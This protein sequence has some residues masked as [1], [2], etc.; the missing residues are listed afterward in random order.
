VSE[1]AIDPQV[2]AL[3]A[4]HIDSVV[5]AEILTLLHLLPDRDVTAA[6][7]GRELRIDSAWAEAQLDHL[8]QRGL[9]TCNRD[10]GGP[11]YKVGAKTPALE[12]A[13]RGLVKAYSERRVTL[14][15]MIFSKPIDKLRSFADAFRIRKDNEKDG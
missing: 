10:D 14:I 12:D 8:C 13:V 11:R 2:R 6:D 9:I 4:D 15:S 3:V 7:V 1:D 5:Q